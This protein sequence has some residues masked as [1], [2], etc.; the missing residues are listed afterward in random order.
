MIFFCFLLF[1]NKIEWHLDKQ[2]LPLIHNQLLTKTLV[3]IGTPTML[4]N[5]LKCQCKRHLLCINQIGNADSSRTRNAT[6]T[7]D[8]NTPINVATRIYECTSTNKMLL[9]I[10][11]RLIACLDVHDLQSVYNV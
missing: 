8:K 9:H 2:L 4:L 7:M 5:H 1:L 3:R 6:C 11:G 10:I